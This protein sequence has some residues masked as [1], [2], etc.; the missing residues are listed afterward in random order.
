MVDAIVTSTAKWI[1]SQL[2]DEVEFLYGV[3]DQL[4]KLQN[5]LESMQQYIQD[6]EETQLDEK[7]NHQVAIFVKTIREIAFR[8]EDVIDTYILEVGSNSKFTRFAC[9]T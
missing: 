6:V 2:V 4:Q 5:D 1:G 7:E 9:F 8:A 3:E